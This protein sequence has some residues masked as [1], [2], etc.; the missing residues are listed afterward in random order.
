MN[1]LPK[2]LYLQKV[3]IHIEMAELYQQFLLRLGK[4][5]ED[6]GLDKPWS[7]YENTFGNVSKFREFIF[8]RHLNG[9]SD[10]DEI[11]E[12]QTLSQILAKAYGENE[13]MK[14]MNVV[15]KSVRSI[16]TQVLSHLPQY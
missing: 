1:N 14:W 4:A 5:Y 11:S 8:M 6:T 7:V 10:L 9:W 16:E 2:L 12:E 15:Q 13:A 3:K